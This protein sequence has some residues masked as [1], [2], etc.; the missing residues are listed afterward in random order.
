MIRRPPRSTRTDTLFP[1]RRSSDLGARDAFPQGAMGRFPADEPVVR[2]P[3]T[4]YRQPDE[5]IPRDRPAGGGDLRLQAGQL[6]VEQFRTEEDALV[7]EQRLC[8]AP[9]PSQ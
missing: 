3:Q 7:A 2:E 5:D 6:D 4:F 8:R 9:G 1:T